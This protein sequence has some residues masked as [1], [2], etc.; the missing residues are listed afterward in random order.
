MKI[1][2]IQPVEGRLVRDPATGREVDGPT[3]VDGD[4]GFWIRRIADSDVAIVTG[5]D[6]AQPAK[7]GVK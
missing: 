5:T 4:D 6:A 1:I 3:Q 7:K 2:T